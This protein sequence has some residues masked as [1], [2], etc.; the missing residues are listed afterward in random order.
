MSNGSMGAIT[1]M[2]VTWR[3]V[4]VGSAAVIPEPPDATLAARAADR[5]EYAAATYL[6]VPLRIGWREMASAKFVPNL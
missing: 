4:G 5:A 1:S 6:E 2:Q 3:Q